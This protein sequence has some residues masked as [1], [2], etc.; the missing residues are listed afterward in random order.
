MNAMPF[1]MWVV[2]GW[3]V[4]VPLTVIGMIIFAWKTGQFKDIEEAKYQML[5]DKKPEPWSDKKGKSQ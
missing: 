3:M 5:E 1:G 4:F 2:V